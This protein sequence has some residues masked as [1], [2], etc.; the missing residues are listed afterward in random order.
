M[1]EEIKNKD[2]LFLLLAEKNKVDS[3]T[4]LEQK[5]V[6][7]E[8]VN[9]NKKLTTINNKQASEINLLKTGLIIL[10]TTVTIE[11]IILIT[12]INN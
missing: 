2:S 1:E 10:G 5:V 7:K 11:T 12:L 6:I 9:T 8:Q 3:T 4:I